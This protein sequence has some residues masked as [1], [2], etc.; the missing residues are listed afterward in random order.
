MKKQKLTIGEV[1]QLHHTGHLEEARQGYLDILQVNPKHTT[2]L[3]LLGVL[4]AEIGDFD[5]AREYLQQAIELEP[6]DP[7][8]HLHFANILKSKGLFTEA[9]QILLD[10]TK[11]HPHFAAAF[12]NL[13]IVYF[14]QDKLKEAVNCYQSAIDIQPDYVDAYYNLGLALNKCKRREEAINA[15]EALIALAPQHAGGRF[16]LGCLLMQL[17]RYKTAVEHFSMI[18]EVY[19]FYFETQ[20]NL[21]ACYLKLG[22]LDEA[23]IHY[24]K[25]LGIVPN[26]IQVLFNL[27][28]I[29]MQQ[30]RTQEA[31]N[32]Y[33]QVI[34]LDPDFFE[35]H[36]NLG[37]AYLAAKNAEAAL[38][39]FRE[40]SRIQPNNVAIGHMIN[41][42]T[43]E[44]NLSASP[45]E[46]IRNL[47]DSYADHYDS[48]LEQSLHYQVPKLIYQ[49]V[50][51]IGT[52][53]FKFIPRGRSNHLINDGNKQWDILDLGC[54]TGLC[55]ELFKSS[56]HSL[57]GVDLSEKMLEI[58][59]KKN[60]YDALIQSDIVPFL[61]DKKEAYDLVI[62]GDVLVY[63]GDLAAVFS[64]VTHALKPQ[65]LFVFNVEI[66]EK[67]EKENFQMTASGRFAHSERYMGL[68][69]E[70]SQLKIL[71]HQVA[72]MRMQNQEPVRGYLYVLQK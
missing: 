67:G 44:K 53:P 56:A 19:P 63:F 11:S 43:R 30:G 25:A 69:A 2:A 27:G 26:D 18:T 1:Q 17:H 13:G 20:T 5:R 68:L 49:A 36:N 29:N 6:K 24:L 41:I 50:Q 59:M 60:I 7:V 35:A 55:G 71:R 39:H 57:V 3:H 62:A 51:E 48:H 66:S 46:Y 47:F 32:Y 21:A 31:I 15:Y 38:I 12:N 72:V 70:K 4:Y 42:I 10:V 16:Q 54:G 65:G 9:V 33:L 23:R 58:A 28:I 52:K 34:K 14:A 61:T 45:P 22:R 64:A 8:I 40:A 37:I